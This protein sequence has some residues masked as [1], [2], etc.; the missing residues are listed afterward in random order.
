MAYLTFF[1]VGNGDM[2]LIQ[3]DNGQN[4]LIDINIRAAADNPDDSTYDV[5]KDLKDRLP[6]DEQGRLYVDAFLVS[7]P[8]ADHVTGLSTH[9][10]LGSPDDFPLGNKNLILIREMWSSPIV[11]RRASTQHKLCEEA[12]AWASEARRRVRRFREDGLATENGDRILIL[13]KDKDGKTDDLGDILIECKELITQVNRVQSGELEGRLLAPIYFEDEDDPLLN[14]IEKNNSSVI[15]RFSIS[16]DGYKEKCLFLSGGD[17]GVAIWKRLWERHSDDGTTDWLQYDIMETPHHCSWRTLS[18]DR[19]SQLGEAVKV[20]PEARD[21]LGQGRE[22]SVIVASCKPIKK[23]DANPPHER[24]KREYLSMVGEDKDR[25]LCT[26]EVRDKEDR[27]VEFKISHR[28]T[29]RTLK[30]AAT[31]GA[32]AAGV[33]AVSTT[34]RGHG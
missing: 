14:E 15:T 22:G 2:A 13:G 18:F 17:A 12:K 20:C 6:R 21:A 31:V 33:S 7:H 24:A 26:E 25:F 10:H 5:A 27:P 28:G 29:Q 16:A 3:L 4:V 34:A 19:W 11:F 8:D 9:F 32:S 23:D 30:L 1:P